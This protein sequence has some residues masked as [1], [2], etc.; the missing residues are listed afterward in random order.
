MRKG[1]L[2]LHTPVIHFRLSMLRN[3]FDLH[4]WP[5]GVFLTANVSAAS[6]TRGKPSHHAYEI[7]TQS[8]LLSERIE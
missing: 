7:P 2:L 3:S 6:I 8:D 1:R 4:L 5:K